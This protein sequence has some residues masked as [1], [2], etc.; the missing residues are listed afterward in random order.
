MEEFDE[1]SELENFLE[2]LDRK[3]E[4]QTRTKKTINGIRLFT[5][6]FGKFSRCECIRSRSDTG[7]VIGIRVNGALKNR[8][9]A[10]EMRLKEFAED[11]QFS[12][13]FQLAKNGLV[14]AKVPTR[15]PKNFVGDVTIRF[16]RIFYGDTIQ[17]TNEVVR[18]TS[19]E[20]GEEEQ[21]GFFDAETALNYLKDYNKV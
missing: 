11:N 20:N 12:N 18:I 10:I 21:V 6:F 1:V 3:L 19:F 15:V 9:L 17:L 5:P 16:D 13:D 2:K 7:R 4:R 14:W 8:F